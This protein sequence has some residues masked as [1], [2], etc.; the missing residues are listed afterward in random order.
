MESRYMLRAIELAREAA[1]DGEVPVGAV[2]VR[3]SDGMIAGEGR[4]RRETMR[5]PL[6]HAELE[7]VHNASRFLGGWRLSGCDM[8]VTLEPCP[9]CAGALIN[10]RIDNV[11]FGAYDGKAGS[12]GSVTDLFSLP[13]NHRPVASGGIMESECSAELKKFFREMRKRKM[14]SINIV[15]AE[16]DDQL[17]RIAAIADEIWHEYFPCILSSEQI[18]YMVEKFC[19]YEAMKNNIENDGYSW[20]FIKHGGSDIGYTAAKPD[21][22]RLFISKIYLKKQERGKKYARRAVEFYTALAR[23]NG[24]RAM[25]LTVNRHND[26]T[27]AAY[28]AMGFEIIGE[29]A[30]DIGQGFVMDDYYM[31]KEV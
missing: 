3:R 31:E 10:A 26:S 30:A 1:A 18:D 28:K 22:D 13:Y 19:S 25:W 9:M 27:I 23:E 17:R 29:G 14:D 6:A 16:T 7:A 11:Y 15:K 2:I 8:Y 24:M 20:Y 12:C 5:D 4:N 21:G